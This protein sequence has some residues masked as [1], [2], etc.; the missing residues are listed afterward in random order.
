MDFFKSDFL[1]FQKFIEF[2]IISSTGTSEYP[3][4]GPTHLLQLLNSVAF[5]SVL[6]QPLM[7]IVKI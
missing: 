2:L 7:K 3:E 1:L 6:F 5:I 4:Q